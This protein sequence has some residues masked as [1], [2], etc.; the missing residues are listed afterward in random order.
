MG[1]IEKCDFMNGLDK[2][3]M[4]TQRRKYPGQKIRCTIKQ[5]GYHNFL[6]KKGRNRFFFANILRYLTENFT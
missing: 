4:S 5:G 2:V 1:E 6:P 3:V